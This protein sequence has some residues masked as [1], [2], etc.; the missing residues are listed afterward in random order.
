MRITYAPS[1]LRALKKLP[2][3][4]IEETKEKILLFTQDSNHPILKVH[5]LTGKLKGQ[6]SFSVNYKIRI[7]FCYPLKSK[8]VI[9]FTAI[10]D[11]DIYKG[12]P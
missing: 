5:K 10:G 12:S 9:F 3:E 6:Y 1:F 11:H 2:V 4:L 7:V 8:Q